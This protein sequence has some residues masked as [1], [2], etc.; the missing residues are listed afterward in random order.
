MRPFKFG[1]H[2]QVARWAT[3]FKGTQTQLSQLHSHQ[4]EGI[5]YQALL[6][7]LF[8]FGMHRQV[9]KW[10]TLSKDTDS[11]WSV[12]FSPDGRHIVSGSH[13]NI[14]HVWDVQM[15]GLVGNPLQGHTGSVFLVAFS[16]D[17][18]HIVS[19]SYDRTI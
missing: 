2:R 17:G 7:R 12:A 1:M 6:M 11:V 13:D 15:G 16:P 4:M 3:L 5:L 8:K 19:G 9:A 10:A 14:I 18:R